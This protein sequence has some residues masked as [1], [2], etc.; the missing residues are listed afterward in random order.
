M[1]DINQ[2]ITESAPKTRSA[3]DMAARRKSD[4]EGFRLIS[5]TPPYNETWTHVETTAAR[6]HLRARRRRRTGR[7]L[8]VQ[9][10]LDV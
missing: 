2:A 6:L 5:P 1:T 7:S 4:S 10:P 9:A 8:R 3:E